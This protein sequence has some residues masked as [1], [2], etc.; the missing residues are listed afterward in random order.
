MHSH[1]RRC[2]HDAVLLHEIRMLIRIDDLIAEIAAIQKLLHHSAVRT[3]LRREQ[4]QRI[5]CRSWLNRSS[6]L[7]FFLEIRQR[8]GYQ[9]FDFIC[10]AILELLCL[11][12]IPVLH[13]TIVSGNAG[14]DLGLCTALRALPYFAG[15][16]AIIRAYR[17]GR[18]DRIIRKLVILSDLPD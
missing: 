16:I 2:L 4:Q 8:S 15:N 5:P 17:I 7:R 14:I 6:S 13:R 9:S 18:A 11:A 3:R 10:P 12:G 1:Q